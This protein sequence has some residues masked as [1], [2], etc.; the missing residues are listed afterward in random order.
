MAVALVERRFVV[1]FALPLSFR[2]AVGP[3]AAAVALGDD[4]FLVETDSPYLGPQRDARNEPTGALRVIGELA[5]LRNAD[6]EAIGAMVR[7]TYDRLLAD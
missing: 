7:G 3:R 5:R 4:D 2:S 6:P 1:S